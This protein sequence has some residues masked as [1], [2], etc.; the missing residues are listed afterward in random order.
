M[1]Y[2]FYN[3]LGCCLIS[4]RDLITLYVRVELSTIPLFLL[5]ALKRKTMEGVEAGMKYVVLGAL[6]SALLLYGLGIFYAL[7]GSME[8][9]R[10]E[11][12]TF[13]S[14]LF[15]LASALV[16]AGIGFK[17][18]IVPF[19]MWAADVYQGAPTPV[20]AYLSVASKG[21]GLA[22]GYQLFFR[23]MA[24][25]FDGWVPIVAILS[26][27]T[28]TLGN[29]VAMKQENIKRFMAFSS[30]SQAGYLLMGF[31]G[32]GGKQAMLFYL[33]VYVMTNLLVF[34]VIILFSNH[35]GKENIS[36]YRGLSRT[37]PVIALCMMLGV[38]SLAGIP[39]LSGFVGKF[40]F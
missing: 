8:L 23:I 19:H 22:F 37:D 21:A 7:S 30:I 18:T 33:L 3:L 6:A 13:S 14:P 5:A 40:F 24:N 1:H 32:E 15:F 39:P 9:D 35:T 17:L 29:L 2:V 16:T 26:A 36:D 27:I 10:L 20:T 28:M 11:I 12:L 4:S 38:F 25:S 31:M 34:G